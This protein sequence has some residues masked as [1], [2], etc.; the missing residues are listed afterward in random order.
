MHAENKN[1]RTKNEKTMHIH[2]VYNPSPISYSSIDSPSSIPILS[3][4]LAAEAE[5][6]VIGDF[7][8]HHPLWNGPTRPTQHTAADHLLDL[9]ENHD[10]SLTLPKGSVTWEARGSFSTID[11]VFMS[12][13]LAERIE[14]CKTRLDLNQSSDHIPISTRILLG[15][16]IPT[17][18]KRRAWKLL[19]MEKLR[20][21]EQTAPPT[22]HP[23]SREEIDEYTHAIQKFLQRVIAAS[24]PWA[25]PSAHA[26]PFWNPE[27]Q[28]RHKAIP[29]NAQNM[30]R[31]I[32]QGRLDSVHDGERQKTKDNSKSENALV[33]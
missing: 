21:A 31:H 4:Q 12:E 26:K 18:I 24:V 17:P 29:Q 14:H 10:L 20:E 8:L 13:Y 25:K 33:S 1:Q 23:R 11:L 15:Y 3:R 6:V 27:L 16:E 2:N 28:R 5:H 7:N 32:S 9:V 19:N 30:E 22:S